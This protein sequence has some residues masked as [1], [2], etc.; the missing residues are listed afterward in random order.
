MTAD[1]FV[2]ELGC[3]LHAHGSPAYRVEDAMTA[4]S[5]ALGLQGSFFA[6]PTA[7]FAAIGPP[8]ARADT[9]LQRVEPGAIDLSRLSGIYDLTED[10]LRGRAD[11]GAGLERLRGLL[12]AK[13]PWGRSLPMLAQA[14]AS[15]AAAAF[16]GGSGRDV[17]VAGLVGLAV[18]LLGLLTAPRLA[19][20]QVHEPLACALAAFLAH[21]AAVLW[22]GTSAP[23][24]TLAGVV[25]LLPGLAL[26]TALTELALRHLAA[27]SARL[28]GSL[29]NLLTMAVGVGM[30]IQVG[31]LCC[32]PTPTITVA[33]LPDWT[34]PAALLAF[35]LSVA[36]LLRARAS[37]LGWVLLAV[38]IA[39]LGARIGRETLGPELGGFGGALAVALAANAYAHLR[40]RPAA[41][42]RIPGLLFL[43]PG[44]LGFR[45]LTSLLERDVMQGI[46]LAL[47]MLLVGASLVA[48]ILLASAL[49]PPPRDS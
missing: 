39:W 38:A 29:T 17:L 20:A 46:D 15:S 1:R 26:T 40:R 23:V 25:V 5:R 43:V 37:D 2:L 13:A 24:V 27:G 7:I 8:G 18:W 16:V 41:V 22:P 28:L 49:L 32:G 10:V 45:G 14:L 47:R 48:G 19:L 11:A 33:A 31:R 34:L 12:A 3:A 6:T 42:L 30:G 44:S 4:S 35:G 9:V 36:V 21:L